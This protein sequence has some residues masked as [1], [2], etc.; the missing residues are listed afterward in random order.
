MILGEKRGGKKIYMGVRKK[1]R[2]KT[3]EDDAK[4]RGKDLEESF[5]KEQNENLLK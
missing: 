1:K 5:H 3:D 4:S 2:K